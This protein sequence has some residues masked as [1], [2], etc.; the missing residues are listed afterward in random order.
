MKF[1]LDKATRVLAKPWGKKS[2]YFQCGF[3]L[4]YQNMKSSPATKGNRLPSKAETTNS[5]T[6]LSL[7]ISDPLLPA[8]DGMLH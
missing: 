4:S 7:S 3:Y 6:T 5:L 2:L 1:F 8:R